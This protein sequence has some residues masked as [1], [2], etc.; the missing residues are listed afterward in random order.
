[1]L[2]LDD[3]DIKNMRE[4][5]RHEDDPVNQRLT[6][7]ALLQGLLF[8]ALAFSWKEAP[9]L[10]PALAVI[11]IISAVS[12]AGALH[13]TH[14]AIG[15]LIEEWESAEKPEVF[16]KLVGYRFRSPG[17]WLRFLYPWQVLP[18]LLILGWGWVV[19]S[20]ASRTDIPESYLAHVGAHVKVLYVAGVMLLVGL[21]VVGWTVWSLKKGRPSDAGHRGES[22]SRFHVGY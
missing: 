1:M 8:T 3:N 14:A 20:L 22:R 11:G 5:I 12:V 15:E 16:N 4:M 10:I 7:L 17:R 9:M 19:Y 13:S 6:W 2:N 21:V 18:W